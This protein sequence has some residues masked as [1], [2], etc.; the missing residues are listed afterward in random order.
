MPALRPRRDGERGAGEDGPRDVLSVAG[1][2][3][4]GTHWRQRVRE[5]DSRAER[6]RERET[7]EQRERERE[8][9]RAI[10]II[11]R[12]GTEQRAERAVLVG[13]CEYGIYGGGAVCY[14]RIGGVSVDYYCDHCLVLHSC[15]L[16]IAIAL[17][18]HS[19]KYC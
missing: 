18:R 16:L 7:A 11:T 8:R 15:T 13:S 17:D 10:C 3:A 9:E 6:E 5:R 1:T 14:G 12:G 19:G 2:T 4:M